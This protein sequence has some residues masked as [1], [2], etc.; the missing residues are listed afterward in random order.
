MPGSEYYDDDREYC[1]T[2]GVET[3][4]SYR[5]YGGM[6]KVH[7]THNGRKVT[8]CNVFCK[9]CYAEK[10][11]HYDASNVALRLKEYNGVNYE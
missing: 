7:S 3:S 10:K 5:N 6:S 8:Y 1:H 9:D 2:C 4:Y 11:P